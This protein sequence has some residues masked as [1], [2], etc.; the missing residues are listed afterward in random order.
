MK[1][2]A[3]FL[4]FV[5]SLSFGQDP[6]DGTWRMNMATLE[7]S[8]TPEEYLL[9]QGMYQCLTCVPKVD[10]R[11]D[12]TDQKVLG[13]PYFDTISV[14]IVDARSV[15]FTQKKAGKTT[16]VAV[17]TVSPDGKT[18]A[19]KFANPIGADRVAGNATFE[20]VSEGPAGSHPLSGLWRMRTIKNETA[21]G[22]VT[23]YRVTKEGLSMS[24]DTGQSYEARFDGGDYPVQGDPA[25]STVS[26]NQIALE[27]IEETVK[28]GG[29]AIIVNRMV[30]SKDGKSMKVVSIDKQ[31]NGTMTY[32]AEKL[33]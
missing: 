27:T 10:V 33:P 29:K 21:K 5:P 2:L 4:L 26:V 17:E 7:F 16:F 1:M 18:M 31:R 11:A 23:T 13:H 3:V 19:E 32:T 9:A 14:R 20:R 28:Q 25:H 12:G 15:E 22:T 24:N 30:V 6:F 8:N